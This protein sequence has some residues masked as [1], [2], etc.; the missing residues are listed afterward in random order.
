MIKFH[1][2]SILTPI[3]LLFLTAVLG[4]CGAE[5]PRSTPQSN[6]TG[7][8][9]SA[10]LSSRSDT[11]YSYKAIY[12]DD[13]LDPDSLVIGLDA[14]MSGDF[15]KSG[16]AI[17]RGI[18]LAVDELN[19]SG[20]VDGRRL[21][22]VVRDHRANPD[23]GVENIKSFAEQNQLLAV[24][25]GMHTPVL[26][27]ELPVI[28]S[29]NLISLVP[30]AAGTSIVDND[31]DPNNVFRLSIRDEHA[32]PFI[33]E[34][35]A[36][37]GYERPALMLENTSWGRSNF[38]SLTSALNEHGLKESSVEWFNWGEPSF[39]D[40]ITQAREK[41]ADA[42]IFVGNAPEGATLVQSMTQFESD[43]R[44][45]IVSHWGITGGQFFQQVESE[46]SRITL[47]VIQTDGLLSPGGPNQQQFISR[48]CSR[49]DCSGKGS[50]A[51]FAPVGTS[52]AYDLV[53]LLARA[54][55]QSDT[56]TTNSIRRQ[57]EN[58]GRW[59]GI[60][61]KYDRPFTHVNREAL[62]ISDYTL[63][64]YNDD[65]ALVPAE[66]DQ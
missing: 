45:P 42:I 23:R 46:L 39:E 7:D 52:H 48:Y 16:V 8:L 26:M 20:G 43:Q 11:S 24:M 37:A 35:L 33:V 12:P 41:G 13:S 63:A 55:N 9:F 51:I 57:L 47:H 29:E 50:E 53:H 44:L 18:V 66:L 60:V 4:G 27:N 17:W 61:R 36:K 15:A 32:G 65:G 34:K 62:S 10:S 6:E 40:N 19:E 30:W 58:L 31:Y 1:V 56:F 59:Q 2:S 14:A 22:I 49:F 54:A 38:K 5:S 64:R 21:Q 25:G 28:H 3:I